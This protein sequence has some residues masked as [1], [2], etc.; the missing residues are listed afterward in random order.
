MKSE[1]K[2]N[3]NQTYIAV[4]MVNHGVIIAETCILYHA[5]LSISRQPLLPPHPLTP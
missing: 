3:G 5:Q 1:E 4:G 2:S